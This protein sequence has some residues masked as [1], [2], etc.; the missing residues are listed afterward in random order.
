LGVRHPITQF[1]VLDAKKVKKAPV[2]YSKVVSIL[3]EKIKSFASSPL[4]KRHPCRDSV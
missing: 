3:E 4:D 1:I 2:C